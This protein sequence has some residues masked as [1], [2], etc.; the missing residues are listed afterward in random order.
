MCIP[1]E[2][3]SEYTLDDVEEMQK[4]LRDEYINSFVTSTSHRFVIYY[5]TGWEYV[6]QIIDDVP[7]E[8]EMLTL[9]VLDLCLEAE[10]HYPGTFWIEC[11]RAF[12][13]NN[14]HV[15][16]GCG[17]IRLFY[18]F[19]HTM[20]K[21]NNTHENVL[22]E[23]WHSTLEMRRASNFYAKRTDL[24]DILA[25]KL[26]RTSFTIQHDSS[27]LEQNPAEGP[28]EESDPNVQLDDV[29][30]L[31]ETYIRSLIA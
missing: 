16:T 18:I 7:L 22:P 14:L 13:Y 29:F 8:L 3:E 12:T 24:L 5:L 1:G 4:G 9:G 27:S 28:E 20:V 25:L 2:I 11:F 19:L 31:T 21:F 10:S 23:I 6:P 15:K 17:I 30:S 26:A